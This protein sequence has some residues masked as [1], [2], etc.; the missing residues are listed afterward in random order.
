VI[1]VVIWLV[2]KDILQ[3][4]R[5]GD[6]LLIEKLAARTT[7]TLDDR[8]AE[9]VAG[10]LERFAPSPERPAASRRRTTRKTAR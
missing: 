10:A 1:G 7:G 9:L 6:P 2:R 3:K 4:V 5:T 8:I